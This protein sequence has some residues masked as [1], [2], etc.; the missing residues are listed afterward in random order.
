MTDERLDRLDALAELTEL[1]NRV[2][3]A[4]ATMR[5]LNR[6][7]AARCNC[8]HAAA[9]HSDLGQCQYTEYPNRGCVCRM[10]AA[11]VRR[12]KP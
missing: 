8:R 2:E 3:V 1:R 6:F 5:F 11:A 9:L 12:V 4:E 10:T 7:A